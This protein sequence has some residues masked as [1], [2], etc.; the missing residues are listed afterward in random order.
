MPFALRK[1]DLRLFMPSC[2]RHVSSGDCFPTRLAFAC[3]VFLLASLVWAT[4]SQ[5]Q[6]FD[7]Y[8]FLKLEYLYDT[9]Q[10]N[11]TREGEFMLFPL[12]DE[13][14]NDQGSLKGFGIFSRIGV[15]LTDLP[16]AMGATTSGVIETDFFGHA[17]TTIS[18]LRLRRAF[19][20]L[21]WG[22]REL[23][24]GQEWSPLFT[25]A[26]FPQGIATTFGAPFQPFARQ[27]QI[28]FTWKPESLRLI[29]VTGWQR[30]AFAD[31]GG[32]KAQFDS[33]LP[34]LHLHAQYL[35]GNSLIGV[36]AQ[37]K[38]SRPNL[39]ADRFGSG[40]VQGYLRLIGPGVQ[41]R[42]KATY[43]SNLADHLMLSGYAFEG[44]R[45]ASATTFE[46]LYLVATWAELITTSRPV[47]VGLLGAYTE[48]LGTSDD[49]ANPEAFN[50]NARTPD[51]AYQWRVAPRL[52]YH[53]GPLRLG[54]ELEVTSAMY[55]DAFDDSLT[56]VTTDSDEEVTNVRGNLV[57]LVNF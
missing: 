34:I 9:R 46:P 16:D 53:T 48:N 36:G 8:G 32:T 5:A 15:R 10:I 27:P 21:D 30:D 17:N 57:F 1:Q 24:V 20:N 19:V 2:I 44:S 13:A 56:P 39:E 18:N 55:A 25:V 14:G 31:I 3:L 11:Q 50:F 37:Q 22:N 4:A 29:G 38:W 51:I 35:F 26:V 6:D 45:R 54:F 41:F 47:S 12:R 40:A 23:L 43:G 52:E 7:P 28:R 42:A 33:G 49:L